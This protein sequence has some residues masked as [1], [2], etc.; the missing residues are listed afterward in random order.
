MEPLL[1]FSTESGKAVCAGV[2]VSLCMRAKANARIIYI[3]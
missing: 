1:V 2:S 3:F